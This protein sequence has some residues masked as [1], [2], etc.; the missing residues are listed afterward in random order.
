LS[1]R[2]RG[3]FR[4]SDLFSALFHDLQSAAKRANPNCIFVVFDTAASIGDSL[5][6]AVSMSI[7][8]DI[9]AGSFFQYLHPANVTLA[10]MI[11]C[12]CLCV[13][14]CVCV[15]VCVRVRVR[16][17]GRACVCACACVCG[18]VCVGV[19]VCVCV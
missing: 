19:C 8:E 17:C 5:S 12:L 10:C 11:V 1:H 13:C 7:A 3:R 2:D 18:R 15:C 6:A 4:G 9:S 14:A 16:A